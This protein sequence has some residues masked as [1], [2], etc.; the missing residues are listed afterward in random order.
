M[1]TY[2]SSAVAYI[3]ENGDELERARLAGLLGRVHPEPKTL[4]SLALRQNDDGGYPY[5]MTP[6]RL[7]AIDS[8]VT[9]LR[10]LHDLKLTAPDYIERAVGYLL[11]LQRP[12]GAWD[13]TPAILR[14]DPPP[15]LRPGRSGGRSFWTALVAFWL[16][17]FIGPTHDTI[18]RAYKILRAPREGEGA[19]EGFT[20]TVVLIAAVGAFVEGPT[21]ATV[22]GDLSA[23][24]HLPPEMW[25][26]E[27]IAN[28]LGAF[29]TARI[30]PDHSLIVWG[31]DRLRAT[32]RTDG[33]W[34]SD[35]GSDREVDLA[36]R[37]LSACLVLG[38][39]AH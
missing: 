19:I 12:E 30:A 7:S 4:R 32:Q 37:A 6:G 13:E 35:L 39:S 5:G 2:L 31:I 29:G 26:T 24:A 16:A 15:H 1:P 28:M 21:A 11:C 10:W 3:E 23:L 9:G 14:Y 34:T 27:A 33:G 38:V 20:K 36:L 8:T 17:R 22:A 18:A 25:T